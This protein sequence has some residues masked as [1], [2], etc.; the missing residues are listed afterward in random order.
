M[1]DA[2]QP[3]VPEARSYEVKRLSVPEAIADSL[4]ERILSGE[5]R[6]GDQLRQEAVAAEYKVSRMPVREALRQLEAAGLVELQIHRGAIVKV[7]PLDE[8]GELFDLRALV[9]CDTLRKAVPQMV[10]SDLNK[11]AVVLAQ[12]ESAYQQRDISAWGALNSAY[13]YSLYVPSDRV[14]SLAIIRLLNDQTDRYIRIQLVGTQAIQ[15]A[16][17]DHRKIL[18]LCRQRRT[19]EVVSFLEAHI[20]QARTDVLEFVRTKRAHRR[21]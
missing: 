14:Q 3:I 17:R 13:H 9:E 20:L 11:A 8:I 21:R 18:C 19:D 12:L 4:R 6:E 15:Q 16:E 7:L 5:F 2:R 10:D 1:V